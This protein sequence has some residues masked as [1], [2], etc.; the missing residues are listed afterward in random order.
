M[1]S[2]PSDVGEE[3]KWC[4]WRASWHCSNTRKGYKSDAAKDKVAF[5]DHA[6]SFKRNAS[7]LLSTTTCDNIKWMFW[8]AGWCTANTRWNSREDAKNDKKRMEERYRSIRDSKEISEDLASTIKEMGW[9]AAWHCAN[10]RVGYRE[11]AKRDKETFESLARRIVK[12]KS[13]VIGEQ[14]LV[15]TME[16]QQ[17]V[18]FSVSVTEGEAREVGFDDG[19]LGF[20]KGKYHPSPEI[21][22]STTLS[23]SICTGKSKTY[24][25]SVTVPPRSAYGANATV[26]EADMDDPYKLTFHFGGELGSIYGTWEGGAV[27]MTTYKVNKQRSMHAILTE[28]CLGYVTRVLVFAMLLFLFCHL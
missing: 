25:F 9:Y 11:D 12:E 10:T 8:E 2:L 21:S 15:I 4:A 20:G 26:H 13:S 24:D 3:M 17:T 27:S 6:D 7:G 22:S 23:Q 1:N 14:Q 28:D 5:D 19:S 16:A 18:S